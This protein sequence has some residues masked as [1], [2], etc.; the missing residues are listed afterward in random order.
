[1][2]TWLETGSRSGFN[3]DGTH[4][5]AITVPSAAGHVLDGFSQQIIRLVTKT[6]E[7]VFQ[8]RIKRKKPSHNAKNRTALLTT[9]LMA[10]QSLQQVQ[11]SGLY[12]ESQ[13]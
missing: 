10:E 5:A 3:P 7:S 12:R 4:A 1:M 13:P 8:D 6:I 9:N 2:M 11:E